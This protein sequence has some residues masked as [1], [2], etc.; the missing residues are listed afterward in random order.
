MVRDII[1]DEA[2][3]SLPS[4]DCTFPDK[5]LFDDLKDT[6]RFHKDRCLGLAANMIGERKRALALYIEDSIK[7]MFNPTI[8][9]ALDDYETEEGC[10]SLDGVRKTKRY[11]TIQ[12]LYFDWRGR[13]KISLFNGIS[14]EVIQHEMDHMNGIL[15]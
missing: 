13:E 11:E 10:L 9:S 2:F 3:L 1:R 6:L 12:V 14:A 15:I 4:Q 7:V 5:K 8:L